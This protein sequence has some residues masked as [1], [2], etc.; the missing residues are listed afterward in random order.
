MLTTDAQVRR[1]FEEMAKHSKIG[2]ASMRSGMDRKTGRKYVKAGMFPSEMAKPRDWRTREDPFEKDWPEVERRLSDAPDLEAKTIFELLMEEF[3]DRYEPGQLRTFQRRVRRWRAASGPSKEVFFP[4]EHR[5]GEGM[6]TDFTWATELGITICGEPFAH[7]LC[8]SVLPYSNWEWA[9]VCRSES[10]SALRK[11]VQSAVFRLGRVAKYHQTD[12]STAATHKLKNGE[13]PGAGKRA[14]AGRGFN[15][16]YISLMDHLGMEP[17]TIK[18]GAKEQNGDVEA[19]N[20]AL[21]RRLE[22]HLLVRG[23]RDFESVEEYE[24]WLS[25]VLKKAN[26]L[27]SKRLAEELAMM[28]PLSVKR[29]PEYVEEDFQV[30]SW[31]TIRV[32]CNSYSV[33]SRLIGEK[34]KV[35]VYDD[36]LEVY[37][38]GLHQLTMERLLG[39][40]GHRINYR[41]IIRSLVRKPGAFARYK[42]RDDLFP[43]LVFRKAY[44]ALQNFFSERKADMEYLRILH[45]A[46][47][48]TE[49]EV[50]AAL[51]LLFEAGTAPEADEVKALAAPREPELPELAVPQVNLNDYDALL[52]EVRP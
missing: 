50:E 8:H 15:D 34:V 31:S 45:L 21:K 19:A 20:G 14:S 1:L 46:A 35:R 43:S 24:T 44:D 22:Q 48:T 36:R 3:P 4:Q 39:K 16:E 51:E 5:P 30:S 12:H 13:D 7:M 47:G 33:P 11:G 40:K 42:Y 52:T 28:R 25:G 49:A 10:M 6:Q 38:C 17:R 32:K 18:V 37:Y 29:L 23:R 41:H 2:L 9:S 27:R 26:V